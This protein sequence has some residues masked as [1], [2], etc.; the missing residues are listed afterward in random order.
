MTHLSRLAIG[1]ALGTA[2]LPGSALPQ[3]FE[4][5][6]D[7][8]TQDHAVSGPLPARLSD[9]EGAVRIDRLPLDVSRESDQAAAPPPD[10]TFRHATVN[11]PVLAGMQVE[12]GSDGRA[13]IQFNDGSIARLTPNSALGIVSLENGGEQLRA[14]RGLTYFETPDR[15]VG[16]A[17]VQVG[18]D[19]V[20]P[21]P[22]SVI[23]MNLDNTPLQV[24]VLSGS[25]HLE[26]VNQSNGFTVNAGQTATLDPASSSAYDVKSDV[27]TESWD[28]WNADRD[29]ELAQMAQGVTDAREAAGDTDSPAWNDLD[30]YGTWY[31]VPGAGMAWAP[32]GVDANF[33]PYGSGAW[34]YYG[35]VGYTWIS[36]YPWGWLPY[37]S[38]N[39]RYCQGFG[40]V[41]QPG[42]GAG[43]GWYPYTHLHH[44]PPS[45]NFPIPPSVPRPHTRL[46][47]APLPKSQ[48]LIPVSRGTNTFRFRQ[49]GGTRP[50]P[51]PLPLNGLAS[52]GAGNPG[53]APVLPVVPRPLGFRQPYGGSA[54]VGN[55]GFHQG[56]PA[57]Y[58]GRS[59]VNGPGVITPSPNIILPGPRVITPGPNVI[60]P[61]P[62]VL[63]PPMHIVQP[64]PVRFSPPPAAV[65]TAPPPT[66]AG[67]RGH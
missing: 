16:D 46:T 49:I 50:E 29:E 38:G 9:A 41:W 19:Q 28:N 17:S 56:P 10:T 42:G 36:A 35:G 20:R 52:N 13:E 26:D 59:F 48:P 12:T 8:A 54:F 58:R 2:M 25:A 23:R 51:R 53:V 3:A 65:R 44:R 67:P 43:A 24:A 21:D 57:I 40:W 47:G 1:F 7:M 31:D 63:P 61:S 45:Y 6:Q 5:N 18:P 11:M 34:G 15:G 39:W 14:L 37:H 62:H 30:Y 55:P 33:D 66:A 60:T 64:P 4:Q 32:D 27:A 22:N